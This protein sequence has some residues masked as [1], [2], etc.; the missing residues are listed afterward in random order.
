MISAFVVFR[1]LQQFNN[2]TI[3]QFRM[4]IKILAGVVLIGILTLSGII[5]F[6]VIKNDGKGAISW[7]EKV[8]W[9]VTNTPRDATFLN[10]SYLYHPAS[11]AGR[12]IFLGWPYFAWSEGYESDR[13][14][15]MKTLYESRDP[16]VF[17]PILSQYSIEYVTV[18]EV[19]NDPNMPTI[20]LSYFQTNFQPAFTSHDSNYSIFRTIDLCPS[21]S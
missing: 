15:I 1:V 8:A 10:S 2:L 18:E 12:S 6:M 17:C 14:R 20:D 5:D 11:L 21:S 13:M 3:K 7:D 4:P 16:G 19:K 9:I